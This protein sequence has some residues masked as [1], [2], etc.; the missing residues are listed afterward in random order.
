[1]VFNIMMIICE[2]DKQLKST[3][4]LDIGNLLKKNNNIP[5]HIIYHSEHFY[6]SFFIKITKDTFTST[7]IKKIKINYANIKKSVETIYNKF[8]NPRKKNILYYGGH[9]HWLFK[10]TNTC[11]KTDMFE[12]INDIELVIFDSCYT[13]YTTLLSSLINKAKYVLACSTASPNL[14]FLNDKFL[15]VLNNKSMGDIKK[16]KKIIDLFIMRNSNKNKLYK[17]FNYRTDASL[18]DLT[19]YKDIETYVKNVEKKST[20]KIENQSY[21]YFYDLKCLIDDDYIN[22]K[23]TKCILYSKVNDLALDH[24]KRKKI[25][26]GGIITGIK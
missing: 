10:D 4:F 26:L 21:Y 16:Y 9:S 23:I 18:I 11:L 6:D 7:K 3:F 25:E 22:H 20:C 5:I 14:G 15:H 2:D 8:Y 12:H 24:Y 19:C 13:S 17:Q 1:M